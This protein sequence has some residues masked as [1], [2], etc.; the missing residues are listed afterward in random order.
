MERAAEREN[1][2]EPL[3]AKQ[4]ERR[5][6]GEEWRGGP[7]ARERTPAHAL[8]SAESAASDRP[9]DRPIDRPTAQSHKW[10]WKG[11]GERGRGIV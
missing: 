1:A 11:G 3:T 10:K 5:G 7:N 6:K 2:S 8:S 4:K 9:T